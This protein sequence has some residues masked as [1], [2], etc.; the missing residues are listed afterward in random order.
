MCPRKRFRPFPAICSS[1]VASRTSETRPPRCRCSRHKPCVHS[2]VR[3]VLQASA[4]PRRHAPPCHRGRA[5]FA[6]AGRRSNLGKRMQR[7]R[8]CCKQLPPVCFDGPATAAAALF[9]V[10]LFRMLYIGIDPAESFQ[11]LPQV[12]PLIVRRRRCS[13]GMGGCGDSC[14]V[15]AP[16]RVSAAAFVCAVRVCQLQHRDETRGGDLRSLQRYMVLRSGVV[17]RP[18][19]V[20]TRVCLLLTCR[21]LTSS[22]S[23]ARTRSSSRRR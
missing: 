23:A 11:T 12:G 17:R 20:V 19:P 7:Q 21:W 1:V 9:V 2:A 14:G 13:A 18:A 10:A 16:R 5:A 8:G 22:C 15:D 3:S 4:K 6:R